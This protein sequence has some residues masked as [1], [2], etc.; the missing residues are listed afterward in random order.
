MRARFGGPLLA[1]AL[2]LA[3]TAAF[4]LVTPRM[5]VNDGFGYDG[6]DYASMVLAFRGQPHPPVLELHSYRFAPTA[7]VAAS[8]LEIRTAFLWLNLIATWAGGLLLFALLRRYRAPLVL[9]LLGVLW[10][11]LLPQGLRYVLIY[12]MQI[13]GVAFPMLVGLLLAALGGRFAVFA[14]LLPVAILTREHA[15]VLVPFLWLHQLPRL[16]FAGATARTALATLPALAVYVLAR[17]ASPIPLERIDPTA[18]QIAL[19]SLR[20]LPFAWRHMLA[21]V[22]LA[23]GVLL[24]LPL[25]APRRT[26]AFLRREPAWLYYLAVSILIVAIGGGDYDHNLYT[27]SPLL[28]VLGFAVSGPGLLLASA[29][30]AALLALHAVMTRAYVVYGT[31]EQS[32]F[33]YSASTMDKDRLVLLTVLNAAAWLAALGIMLASLRRRLVST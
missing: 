26:A 5:V 23:L 21:A 3:V 31:D 24:L 11:C 29:P 13:D 22:P 33:A 30:G 17:V 25:A 8:G 7:L 14:A 12:P 15:L 9:A 10:W 32:Y 1:L 19:E 2:L 16:G 18:T 4:A 20:Q 27:L 6:K 28:L